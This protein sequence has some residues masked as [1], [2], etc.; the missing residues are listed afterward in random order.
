[1]LYVTVATTDQRT[2]R[3]PHETDDARVAVRDELA[4]WLNADIGEDALLFCVLVEKPG[5]NLKRGEIMEKVEEVV[6]GEQR[7]TG[8]ELKE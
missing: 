6:A 2:T 5:S 7:R 4:K 3:N 1:M 8:D